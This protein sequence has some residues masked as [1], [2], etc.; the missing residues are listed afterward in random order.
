MITVGKTLHG[1][2]ILAG[3]GERIEVRLEENGTTGYRWEIKAMDDQRLKYVKEDYT[4]S[5]EA[6]GAGG[7]K[8]FYFEVVGEGVSTLTLSLV[9]TWE[10]DLADTFQLTIE[11]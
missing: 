7:M 9:N 1:R 11:S 5:G 8:S 4:L 3:K 10:K 6:P 2:K